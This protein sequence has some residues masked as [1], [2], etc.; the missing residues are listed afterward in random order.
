MNP[1]MWWHNWCPF[2]IASNTTQEWPW[3]VYAKL[4]WT[5]NYCILSIPDR[6]KT[7]ITQKS[8]MRHI[9]IVSSQNLFRNQCHCPVAE[10]KKITT[11]FMQWNIM[12]HIF[13]INPTCISLLCF[14]LNWKS[15]IS[16]WCISRSEAATNQK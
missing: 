4:C 5:E 9:C 12:L 15:N 13:A 10:S 7:K 1:F 11:S 14:F 6:V 3:I 2:L 8:R 16:A